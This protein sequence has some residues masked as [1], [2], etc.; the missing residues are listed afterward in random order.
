MNYMEIYNSLARI[1]YFIQLEEI[2]SLKEFAKK[3]EIKKRTLS[4]RIDVLR[5]F[6][7]INGAEIHYDKDRKTYYFEPRGKFI[8]FKFK[9]F[10]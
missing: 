3:C 1:A 9:E 5:Q 8:D 6:T 7:A 4:N 2:G 10:I